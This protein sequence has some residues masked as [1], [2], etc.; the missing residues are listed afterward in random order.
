MPQPSKSSADVKT[1]IRDLCRAMLAIQSE[2]DM[3]AF[4]HE[5]CPNAELRIMRDRWSVAKMMHLGFSYRQITRKTGASSST[6]AR[7]A[8]SICFGSG[9]LLRACKRRQ[10]RLAREFALSLQEEALSHYGNLTPIPL[11]SIEE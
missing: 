2:E 3:E 9:Q 6:I 5:L 8:N 10:Q 4:L 11:P 1:D 7:V